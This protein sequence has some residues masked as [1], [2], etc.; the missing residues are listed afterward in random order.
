MEGTRNQNKNACKKPLRRIKN[1][2]ARRIPKRIFERLGTNR[3]LPRKQSMIESALSDHFD[4]VNA[5][6]IP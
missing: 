1:F 3:S 5:K 2:D 4:H 6:G